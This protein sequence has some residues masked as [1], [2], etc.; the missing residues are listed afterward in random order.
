M[1]ERLKRKLEEIDAFFENLT[2]EEYEQI[3][4]E[5]GMDKPSQ[6][7]IIFDHELDETKSPT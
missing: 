7:R 3:A 1:T 4:I 6:G 5:C 2:I